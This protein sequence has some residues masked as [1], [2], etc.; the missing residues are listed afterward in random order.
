MPRPASRVGS[1]LAFA[2]LL[3]CACPKDQGGGSIPAPAQ[4]KLVSGG[5][6]GA[7][8]CGDLTVHGTTYSFD[9]TSPLPT[10]GATGWKL[11]PLL[12][13]PNALGTQWPN[14]AIVLKVTTPSLNDLDVKYVAE[15]GPQWTLI[16]VP[17]GR[18][19]PAPVTS[20]GEVGVAVSD[21]GTTKTWT[22]QFILDTCTPEAQVTMSAVNPQTK[23]SSPPLKA[24]LFR[25]PNELECTSSGGGGFYATTGPKAPSPR[26]SNPPGSGPCPNGGTP[27]TFGVCE[28]CANLHPR[29]MNRWSAGQYC[30][31]AEVM[32]VY[33][34]TDPVINPTPKAQTCTVRIEP[35]RANCEY[36]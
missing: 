27:Q 34:Y 3:L 25:D 6:L 31:V 20:R 36:P 14:R 30:D 23:A 16:Q 15:T 13:P 11:T 2:I 9:C 29:S 35:N 4:P 5:L 7:R 8:V 1:L 26:P 22:L 24:E 12:K 21:D 33:G 18:G 28:N 19:E 17:D 10:T 32:A